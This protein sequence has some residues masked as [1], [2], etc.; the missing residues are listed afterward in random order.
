MGDCCIIHICYW[1]ALAQEA[2]EVQMMNKE[3]HVAER[4][5]GGYVVVQ[6]GAAHGGLSVSPLITPVI[7][8]QQDTE[9]K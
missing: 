5:V 1:C 9:R 8:K 6:G 7:E 2:Q 3:K 4:T